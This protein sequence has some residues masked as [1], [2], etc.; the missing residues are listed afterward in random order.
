MLNKSLVIAVTSALVM[1]EGA[2]VSSKSPQKSDTGLTSTTADSTESGNTSNLSSG[3]TS[4][5]TSGDTSTAT[6][7]GASTSTGTQ[8][9][10][11][12]GSTATGGADTGPSMQCSVWMQDCPSGMKCNPASSDGVSLDSTQCVNISGSPSGPGEPCEFEGWIV[13]PESCDIGSFCWFRDETS[14]TGTCVEVC[15]GGIKDPKCSNEDAESCH[16]FGQA[17]NLNLC[18]PNCNP[19]SD[20]SSGS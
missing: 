14:K 8:A 4:T 13:Q 10:T 9:S 7:G 3:D 5:G 18:L 16:I 2:C 19:L 1:I 6:S 11:T 12:E 15:A 17:D 20:G